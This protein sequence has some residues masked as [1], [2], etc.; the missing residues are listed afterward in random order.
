MEFIDGL[1][2][3]EITKAKA[4]V[5]N[6]GIDPKVV[7]ARG[8]DLVLKQIFEHGFFHADPHPGNIKVLKDNVICF[9]DYGMMGSLSAR[10]REDLA[11]ILIAIVDKDETKITKTILKLNLSIKGLTQCLEPSTRQAIAR[12]LPL[13]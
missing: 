3:S 13:F 7:A 9:L 8:A 4:Q 1:K 5:Q 11:D 12:Y 6:Y 2:V 10:H